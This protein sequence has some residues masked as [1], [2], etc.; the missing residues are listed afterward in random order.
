MSAIDFSIHNLPFGIFDAGS[1]PRAGV[2]IGDKIV[3]LAE[4][5]AQGHFLSL[6]L[7]DLSVFSQPTLNSFIA[8]GKLHWRAVRE[9]V[10]SLIQAGEAVLVEQSAAKMLLP[11]EIGDYVDFY[12]SEEHATNLG[13]MFRDPKNALLPNWKHLPVGYHG[14]T[15]SIIPSGGNFHRPRGQINPSN[16]NPEFA[17]TRQLDFELEMGFI[18]GKTTPLG[19]SVSVEDAEDCI[20]GMVLLNDWSAR[21]IQRWE[22]VPLGPF[23]GKSFATSMT[24]WI[25][26]LDALEPFRLDGPRQDPAPLPYLQ[27]R[28]A[29]NFDIHLEVLLQP[30]QEREPMLISRTNF[31]RVYW[32]MS[33]QL[34]HLTSN[35]TNIRVGDLCGSGTISGETPDSFGSMLEICWDGTKPL[36]FPGGEIRTFLEDGDTVVMRAYGERAG[37]RVGFGELRTKILP[38]A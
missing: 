36:M 38:P 24:P 37:M 8:L 23:L 6:N 28:G 25:V 31:R 12:S 19:S 7:P 2:A 32:N 26:T 16:Q 3:D 1:G 10:S 21:D 22:Y 34:A 35:G 9:R 14:R 18:V 29:R 17:P 15:S 27:S 4:G 5:A 20:F 13:K 30:D 11:V 33:Q